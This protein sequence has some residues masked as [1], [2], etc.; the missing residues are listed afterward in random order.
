MGVCSMNE[1][2]QEKPC[3]MLLLVIVSISRLGAL[4]AWTSMV[5]KIASCCN[6]DGLTAIFPH[7]ERKGL[8]LIPGPAHPTLT[9]HIAAPLSPFSLYR[10]HNE[11]SRKKEVLRGAG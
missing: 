8:T 3:F 9:F 5:S 11:S 10:P 2:R 4:L 6:T 7:Y 1:G